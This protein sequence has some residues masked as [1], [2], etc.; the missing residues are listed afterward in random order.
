MSRL[1]L[2]G[3][4]DARTRARVYWADGFVVRVVS[5]SRNPE[6]RNP[7][8]KEYTLTHDNLGGIFPNQKEAWASRI[9]VPDKRD[10][11]RFSHLEGLGF[12]V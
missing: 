2:C 7:P 10:A 12:R 6:S 11:H 8:I 5:G 4:G 3:L 9:R 1:L